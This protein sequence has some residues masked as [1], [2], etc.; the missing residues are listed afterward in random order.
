M[1]LIIVISVVLGDLMI[2]LIGTAIPASRLKASEIRSRENPTTVSFSLINTLYTI[3]LQFLN[4]LIISSLQ[5]EKIVKENYIYICLRLSS[6]SNQII[7]LS[8]SFAYKGLLQIIAIFMAFHTRKV[9][10]KALND[11][12]ETAAI[13]YINSIILIILCASVFL[14]EEYHNAH[15]AVFGLA[16]FVQ[17]SLFLGLLFIPKV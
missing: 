3:I 4:G 8:L 17:A 11:S 9:K 2:L 16:L 15:A 10:I 1:L 7:W 6:D 5:V 14:L 13:I 12:K